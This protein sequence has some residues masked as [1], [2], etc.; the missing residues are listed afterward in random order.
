VSHGY[1]L[2]AVYVKLL[3]VGVQLSVIGS[4]W[5]VKDV[6]DKFLEHSGNYIGS[7]IRTCDSRN[8]N[9]AAELDKILTYSYLSSK[10]NLRK[11]RKLTQMFQHRS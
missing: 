1:T 4:A 8:D 10:K 3:I 7:G 11:K 6:T 9:S 5:F 2:S